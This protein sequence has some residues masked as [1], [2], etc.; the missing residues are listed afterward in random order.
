MSDASFAG[1][2]SAV[3]TRMIPLAHI[4]P[5][6]QQVRR[7][8]DEEKMLSL[9]AS[10]RASGVIQP[11]VVRTTPAAPDGTASLVPY[12]IIAGERR[13]RASAIAG[14]DQIPA[15][16][17]D[18][19]SEAD[20]VVLQAVE[21]FQRDDLTLGETASAVKKLVDAIG[22]TETHKKLG[23]SM[24]W[25]SKHARIGEL[26]KE[27]VQLIDDQIIDSAD[28]AFELASLK[29]LVDGDDT[30]T[31]MPWRYTTRIDDARSKMLTR[32]ELREHLNDCREEQRRARQSAK[33]RAAEADRVQQAPQAGTAPKPTAEPQ[34]SSL[35][36][37][38]DKPGTQNKTSGPIES[39]HEH[40]R[41]AA[42]QTAVNNI[43]D[44]YCE[45]LDE[46]SA[47]FCAALNVSTDNIAI[48]GRDYQGDLLEDIPLSVEDAHVN[49]IAQLPVRDWRRLLR[50]LQLHPLKDINLPSTVTDGVPGSVR[51]FFGNCVRLNASSQIRSSAAYEAY[52]RW[53]GLHGAKPI[54]F[55][56]TAWAAAWDEIAVPRRRAEDGTYYVGVEL[57][58]SGQ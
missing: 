33:D 5:D 43:N 57:S 42:H 53:A 38:I 41:R 24:P 55:K 56:A 9:A 50:L 11:I 52:M 22:T 27:I 29:E 20:A 48:E 10:I 58:W 2:T 16:V 32:A 23:K 39:A 19:L 51:D 36:R 28:I 18:D 17:R 47:S 26:P 4:Q 21:N 7:V 31:L 15:T 8:F 30:G 34:Q 44:A 6:A 3:L 12:Q 40:S 54:A 25:V 46:L 13:W 37:E 35:L 14:L 1:K 45:V 49:L